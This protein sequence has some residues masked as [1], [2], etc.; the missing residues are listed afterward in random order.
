MNNVNSTIYGDEFG[1]TRLR[2]RI[3][4]C[5][6]TEAEGLDFVLKKCQL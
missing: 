2:R 4:Q 1:S 6:Q 3:F 5:K